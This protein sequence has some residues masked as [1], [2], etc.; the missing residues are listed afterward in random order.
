MFSYIA[1]VLGAVLVVAFVWAIW[2]PRVLR[3]AHISRYLKSLKEKDE[4][5]A[6]R[7]GRYLIRSYR[8]SGSV[9]F[10]LAV[11]RFEPISLPI[12]FLWVAVAGAVV[13]G[14]MFFVPMRGETPG[15]P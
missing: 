12:S 8:W 4:F 3:M 11:L 10:G 1:Q 14:V 13:F 5:L 6:S 15:T 7:Q 9:F 2:S